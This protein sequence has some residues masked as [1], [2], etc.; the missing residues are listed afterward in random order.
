MHFQR[1]AALR[2]ARADGNVGGEHHAGDAAGDHLV[3]EL[4]RRAA[5]RRQAAGEIAAGDLAGHVL[6]QFFDVRRVRVGVD[7][8]EVGGIGAVGVRDPSR[9]GGSLP[10]NT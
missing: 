8:G 1:R 5:R 2:Q 6:D 9:G 10:E 4:H 3:G 7:D